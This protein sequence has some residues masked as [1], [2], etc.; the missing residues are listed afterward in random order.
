MKGWLQ[1]FRVEA[2]MMERYCEHGVGHPDPDHILYISMTRGVHRASTET[3]HG[4]DGCC[5]A[6]DYTPYL[7]GSI[8][9]ELNTHAFHP[10]L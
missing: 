3:V 2:Y 8:N 7:N 5:N 1:R 10:A 6:V 9:E 4:C